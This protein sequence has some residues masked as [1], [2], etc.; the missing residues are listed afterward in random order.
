MSG[1]VRSIPLSIEIRRYS[2][3]PDISGVNDEVFIPQGSHFR[4]GHL[5]VFDLRTQ[6]FGLSLVADKKLFQSSA[7]F[8]LNA[9]ARWGGRY[10]T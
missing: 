7:V 2:S 1:K 3:D 9:H 8:V 6:R 5:S 10:E 4:P